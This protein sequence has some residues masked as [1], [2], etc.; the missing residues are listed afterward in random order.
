MPD[1]PSAIDFYASAFCRDILG[2]AHP[3]RFSK[4]RIT[5]ANDIFDG[6]RGH[7]WLANTLDEIAGGGRLV[8]GRRAPLARLAD[9][10]RPYGRLIDNMLRPFGRRGC[11]DHYLTTYADDTPV[12]FTVFDFDRHVPKGRRD[13]LSVESEEWLSIDD[14][15][16]HKVSV[17][18]RLASHLDVDVMWLQSPGRWMIDGH[19]PSLPH[20]RALRGGPPRAAHAIRAS[21]HARR[22]QGPPRVGGRDVVGHKE[23]KHTNPRPGVHGRVPGRSRSAHHHS[24]SGCRGVGRARDEHGSFGG[25][26]G[27]VRDAE[28]RG[29]ETAAEGG[30]AVAQCPS[31][32][33]RLR[34][35]L[36]EGS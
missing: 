9:G 26:G 20:V 13:P 2:A 7:I 31:G 35:G 6:F 12:A 30:C 21:P 16:W 29:R 15:F 36:A 10:S 25:H 5:Y 18:Q 24:H 23:P 27:R 19:H 17:F 4:E 14:A 11:K 33:G 28:A 32:G 8:G 1:A 22:D 3:T 34:R